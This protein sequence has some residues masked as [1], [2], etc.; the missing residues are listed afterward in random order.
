MTEK[1]ANGNTVDIVFM[2][3]AKV[4]DFINHTILCAKRATFGIDIAT[5]KWI[6]TI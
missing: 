6:K 4:F 5:P 2:D 3:L 1:R